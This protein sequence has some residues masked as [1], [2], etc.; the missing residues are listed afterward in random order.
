MFS[1]SICFASKTDSTYDVLHQIP[2][3][4]D[5]TTKKKAGKVKKQL[6]AEFP[7]NYR[8]EIEAY[9]ARQKFH[10]KLLRKFSNL[11]NYTSFSS[12]MLFDAALIPNLAVEFTVTPRISVSASWMYS[13]ITLKKQDIFWRIYGGDITARYWLGNKSLR[14]KLTGHHIGAYAQALTYDF[15]LGGQAQMTDGWNYA[16]GIEY[17]HSFVISKSLNIDVFAGVG[18]LMGNY[19]D[20]SNK[21]GHYTWEISVKRSTVFPTKLGASLVWLLPFKQKSLIYDE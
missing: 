18:L 20:Y 11:K 14:R 16:A 7:Q 8:E 1:F 13:W 6:P 12:N 15:D 5:T 9:Y 17:G 4:Q 21:D 3:Q 2:S 10:Q 19:H